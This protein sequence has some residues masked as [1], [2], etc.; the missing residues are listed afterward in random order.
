MTSQQKLASKTDNRR[1][2]KRL[3]SLF[4]EYIRKRAMKRCGGCERCHAKKGSY[5]DLQTA[6]FHSR[7]KYT[8]RWD[9]RN[10]VGM[11]GGCHMYLDSHPEDKIEFERQILGDDYD[12]LYVLAHMTTKQSPIDYILVEIYLKQLLEQLIENPVGYVEL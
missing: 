11:C 6:H 5:K 12:K 8:L 10:A 2:R 4:R 1:V 9:E 3:D 7:S